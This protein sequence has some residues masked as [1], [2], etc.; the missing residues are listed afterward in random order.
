MKK[1]RFICVLLLIIV[2]GA[3]LYYY[4]TYVHENDDVIGGSL[5]KKM[6]SHIRSCKC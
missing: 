2:I 5:V 1:M 3:G 4:I 6:E